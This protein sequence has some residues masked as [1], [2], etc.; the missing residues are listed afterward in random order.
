MTGHVMFPVDVSTVS[1]YEI[2]LNYRGRMLVWWRE[3]TSPTPHGGGHAEAACN[4][5][6]SLGPDAGGRL[7]T[8]RAIT[9]ILRST[10]PVMQ[11]LRSVATSSTTHLGE[12]L[13][14]STSWAG[15][16]YC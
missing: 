6:Q 14:Y 8:V 9:C 13:I 2:T 15:T 12:F 3:A 7:V 1:Q 11:S 16:S 5:P 4:T 10:A